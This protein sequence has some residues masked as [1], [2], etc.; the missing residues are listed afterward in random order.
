MTLHIFEV[1]NCD[2]MMLCLF[3]FLA[4]NLCVCMLVCQS[5]RFFLSFTAHTYPCPSPFPTPGGYS[6]SF[7]LMLQNAIYNY[8]K[9]NVVS[10]FPS[11]GYCSDSS[12]TPSLTPSTKKRKEK[13]EK[14]LLNIIYSPVG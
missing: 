13:K 11:V 14:K 7:F 4:V 10:N 12:P 8:V 1:F 2:E 3:V 6:Y 9:I 5:I